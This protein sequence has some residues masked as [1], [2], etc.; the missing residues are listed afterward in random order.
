MKQHPTPRLRR[1]PIGASPLILALLLLCPG[2]AQA[3]QEPEKPG[4]YRITQAWDLPSWLELGG[5]FRIRYESLSDQY[6][7][8]SGPLA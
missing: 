1:K 4:P 8:P 2:R 7:G 6:R 3:S 5:H